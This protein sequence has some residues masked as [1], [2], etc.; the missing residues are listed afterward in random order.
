[1]CHR[2]PDVHAHDVVAVGR[3]GAV[4][5]L[6]HR[7]L[8]TERLDDAQSAERLLHLAHRVA[9][10]GL[11]L[12]ALLLQL[13]SDQSHEPSEDGHED[14]GEQRELPRHDDERGEIDQDENRVF[15]QHVERC[16]DARLYLLHVA[17]HAGD[18]VALTLLGEEA[19]VQR[20]DL[21]IEL[22]SDVAHH[23]CTNRDDCCR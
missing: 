7:L 15:E 20:V 8:G 16:H 4:E 19:E 12:D 21:L 2:L 6:V 11:C 18:D 13:T 14:D 5:T 9:P 17:A 10:Q 23:S 22:V 3:V 1:M